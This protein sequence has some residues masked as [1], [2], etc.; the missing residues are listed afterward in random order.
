[1]DNVVVITHGWYI[2]H[3]YIHSSSQTHI[4]VH[5]FIKQNN[6]L[7]NPGDNKFWLLYFLS[8]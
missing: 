7:Y 5:I 2:L 8:L 4:R 6:I 1:M 3:T